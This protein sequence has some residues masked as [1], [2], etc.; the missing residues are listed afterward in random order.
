MWFLI[1]EI[2]QVVACI[3]FFGFIAVLAIGALQN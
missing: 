2:A 1:Y 3:L